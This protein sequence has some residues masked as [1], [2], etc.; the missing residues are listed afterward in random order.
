MRKL[1]IANWKSNKNYSQIDTWLSTFEKETEVIVALDKLEFQ[2]V[3]CP[4][5]PLVMHLHEWQKKSLLFPHVS[6]G[7]QDIS[8]F[9][10][11]SYTGAVSGPNLEGLDIRYA[12]VGHS[13]RRKYFKETSKDVALKVNQCIE[14]SITPIICVD[15]KEIAAQADL[16]DPEKYKHL[17]I[18]YE[19][20]EYIGTGMSQDV[21]EVL[22]VCRE[23]RSAFGEAIIIYGGSVNP[24]NIDEFLEHDEVEGFLVGTASL[25]PEEFV[26]LMKTK[27]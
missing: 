15:R 22:A 10:A 21:T 20:I 6:I 26:D 4:P 3:I 27:M 17:V 1:L 25:D 7:V 2:I 24:D 8:P 18:A 13:E 12:I 9:P 11:G 5:T 19:P 16:I 23:I 14:N